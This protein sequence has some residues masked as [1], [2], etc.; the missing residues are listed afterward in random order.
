L[1][2]QDSKK[3]NVK[4]V[5][6]DEYPLMDDYK[7]KRNRK[8][9]RLNKVVSAQMLL[10][11]SDR[12]TSAIQLLEATVGR[13]KTVSS[14]NKDLKL[15]IST[16]KSVSENVESVASKH[17][18]S[19]EM[20]LRKRKREDEKD[21][22]MLNVRP[23]TLKN[24]TLTKTRMEC[25]NIIIDNKKNKKEEVKLKK[26]NK[27]INKEED[28]L[29]DVSRFPKRRKRLPNFLM[30][31]IKRNE[32][33][34]SFP[35]PSRGET[36]L[37]EELICLLESHAHTDHHRCIIKQLIKKKLIPVTLRSVLKH[38]QMFREGKALP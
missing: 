22:Y 34:I 18:G 25:K 30:F 1:K 21:E 28:E 5:G 33:I 14:E 10:S 16:L 3:D 11:A 6:D 20:I 13:N 17:L 19:Y 31:Q 9:K 27:K 38:R 2:L 26:D 8:K 24:K 35:K 15:A 23:N 12:Y 29:K 32:E 36:Y 37:P 4:T 7:K